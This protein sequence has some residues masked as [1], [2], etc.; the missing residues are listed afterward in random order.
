MWIE[1][2][3][4]G[5]LALALVL[6]ASIGALGVGGLVMWDRA[7]RARRVLR[8]RWLMAGAVW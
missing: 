2:G 1:I 4:G 6:L 8:V 5:A 3:D 7:E